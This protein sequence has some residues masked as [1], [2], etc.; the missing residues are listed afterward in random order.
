MYDPGVSEELAMKALISGGLC[1]VLG[2]AAAPCFAD[3]QPRRAI[4]SFQRVAPAPNRAANSIPA[5]PSAPGVSLSR[6]IAASAGVAPAS[7][8]PASYAPAGY[9]PADA[10][11]S[12]RP[13]PLFRAKAPELDATHQL[14]PLGPR[15]TVLQ[16]GTVKPMS[17]ARTPA[18]LPMFAG[19]Q[20]EKL[21]YP[22]SSTP[23]APYVTQT[24]FLDSCHPTGPVE[25]YPAAPG[26]CYVTEEICEP[27]GPFCGPFGGRLRSWTGCFD[28]CGMDGCCMP[29]PY[30][31][32]RAEYL[33]WHISNPDMPPL[34]TTERFGPRP[35]NG[36]AGTL[37]QADTVFDP[38]EEIRSGF[39]GQFGFW[40]P[41]HGKWGLDFGGFMLVR[42]NNE[43]VGSSDSLGNPVL[44]RPFFDT[45]L[46]AE[47]AQIVSY[48]E[49]FAGTFTFDSVTKLWGAD[50]N[51]RR[52][53]ACGPRW[54]L[55]GF[56]GWRHLTLHDAVTIQESIMDI[57]PGPG[58][59]LGFGVRDSFETRNQ[60]NGL[61]F[62]FEGE[63]R[64]LRRWFVAGSFK[65]AMGNMHQTLEIDGFTDFML[66]GGGRARGVGGLY[67]LRSNIGRF[68]RNE[69]A[70]IPEFG[71][72]LGL[73]ITDNLRIYAGY[74]VLCISDVL[75]AGEQIDR[76]INPNM[77]PDVGAPGGLNPP[78][79][80]PARPAVLF[81]DS[82]FWAGGAQFGLEYHW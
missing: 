42:R 25:C 52:K 54:W 36:G 46:G 13:A 7:Y 28:A 11:E 68:A 14:M 49:E 47:N 63:M 66:P 59:V 35:I 40:F 57:N 37:P 19:T 38:A 55:D 16:P 33:L 73:D 12:G 79:V 3:E 43:F 78:L 82:T 6:P 50:V 21:Q 67:A 75:R 31:W 74:N 24:P 58:D 51:L 1:A 61:Q 15:P 10:E 62:G 20:P 29:R 8:A 48:P 44:A 5:P 23:T 71:I 80:A 60:F 41:W 17:Q 72:K 9:A 65:F 70:V 69:F 53:L 22:R 27:C 2:M 76:S 26:D 39:R 77:L 45:T 81:R 32:M 30:R 34:L 56:M 4:G 64:L 18:P